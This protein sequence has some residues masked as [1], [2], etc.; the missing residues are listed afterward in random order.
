MADQ[1]SPNY[2][3]IQKKFKK[4]P[5]KCQVDAVDAYQGGKHV[6]AVAPTG[7]GKTLPLIANAIWSDQGISIIISALNI[8]SDQILK[9]LKESSAK[10]IHLRGSEITAEQKQARRV[11]HASFGFNASSDGLSTSLVFEII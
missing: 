1:R 10:A 9:L 2:A 7:N 11:F 4:T 6:I 3:K 8:I 5:C